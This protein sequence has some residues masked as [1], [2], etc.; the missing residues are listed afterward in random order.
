MAGTHR[1]VASIT[2]LN[3]TER[4]VSV[5]DTGGHVARELARLI[6]SRRSKT[7]RFTRD[8]TAEFGISPLHVSSISSMADGIRSSAPIKCPAWALSTE[9]STFTTPSKRAS[10]L[11]CLQLAASRVGFLRRV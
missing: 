5:I 1:T 2:H 11:Y 3:G 4:L 10:F 7:I 8:G 6:S 9:R